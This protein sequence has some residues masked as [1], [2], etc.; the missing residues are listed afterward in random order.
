[1]A[2][3]LGTNLPGVVNWSK[4]PVPVELHTDLDVVNTAV[5]IRILVWLYDL[6]DTNFAAFILEESP[7]ADGN[8][9]FDLSGV[10]D[11]AMRNEWQTVKDFDDL[12][13]IHAIDGAPIKIYLNYQEMQD[14]AEVSYEDLSALIVEDDP[15]WIYVYQGGLPALSIMAGE[16]Y[17]T[18][19]FDLA[20]IPEMNPFL[21]WNTLP[22]TVDKNQLLPFHY[23]LTQDVAGA[24]LRFKFY[25]YDLEIGSFDATATGA[26]SKWRILCM[27]A[28]LFPYIESGDLDL[29]TIETGDNII[30]GW[31]VQLSTTGDDYI[32]PVMTFELDRYY[33][34]NKN[35]FIFQNSLNGFDD[36]RFIGETEIGIANDRNGSSFASLSE[37]VPPSGIRAMVSTAEQYS[38]KVNTGS[39]TKSEVDKLRELLLSARIYKYNPVHEEAVQFIPVEITEKSRTLI[40]SSDYLNNQTIEFVNQWKDGVWKS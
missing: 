12:H 22:R 25:M 15:A 40:K 13:L 16:D 31:T 14:G 24:Y 19:T 32:S 37:T 10:L 36:V 1:M 11:D 28:G 3:T 23:L 30:T 39:L 18:S 8:V 7:D 27:C 21:T 4:N 9:T 38:I 33:H 2:I 35:Y 29:S 17:W 26:H 6:A 20:T 5:R 34:R